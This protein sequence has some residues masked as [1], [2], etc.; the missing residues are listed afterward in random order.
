MLTQQHPQTSVI[1]LLSKLRR[2]RGYIFC[3]RS[4]G[5]LWLLGLREVRRADTIPQNELPQVPAARRRLAEENERKAR[6]PRRDVLS[7]SFD[8]QPASGALAVGRMAQRPSKPRQ[9]DIE[10]D[11]KLSQ[12]F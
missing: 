4:R 9:G 8:A 7:R 6:Y 5:A 12:V 1:S 10:C 2:G 3:H 11:A